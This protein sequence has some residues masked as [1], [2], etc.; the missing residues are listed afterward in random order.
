MVHKNNVTYLF[1]CIAA[2]TAALSLTV[3]SGCDEKEKTAYKTSYIMSTVV[4][5]HLTG[6]KSEKIACDIESLLYGF[7]A[8]TSLYSEGSY[9]YRI[10]D[11]AGNNFVE[12][13]EG[14]YTLLSNAKVC[15]EQSDGI[16]DVTIA[17]LTL[18]WNINGENPSVPAEADITAARTLIN[19]K[20]IL[21]SNEGD[22]YK[23]KL[24]KEGE[25]LDLGGIAKGYSL[26]LCKDVLAESEVEYG[27]ISI[28]GNVL[29]YGDK[30]GAGFNVGLRVPEKDSTQSFC[31]LNL[32]DTI[33]ST[34][35]GYER[36]FI[37]DGKVY[38]HVLDPRTGYPSNSDLISVSVVNNSGLTADFLSTWLYIIGKDE[39][40]RTANENGYE[41]VLVDE[42]G[43]VYI[44]R[45]LE[46]NVVASL[47][48]TDN[49]T[50]K[51]I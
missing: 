24:S 1:K 17:P 10:N 33:V 25:A 47:C 21:L 5:Q 30:G 51:F 34:T 7:E 18:L 48:D 6:N 43:V 29:V 40:V 46:D 45:S 9:V 3:I 20:D 19:Y 13:D 44:S 41:V 22:I 49:Y 8:E 28:G 32:S 36:Y 50:F 39:A 26:D 15:C 27:Y 42:D 31:V 11:G 12:I 23:A 16:F 2:V 37:E 14:A 38:H 35:G 4:I